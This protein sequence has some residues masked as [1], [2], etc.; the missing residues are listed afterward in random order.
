MFNQLD[1]NGCIALHGCSTSH[2]SWTWS[3]NV[4]CQIVQN[5]YFNFN[6]PYWLIIIF[7]K[8]CAWPLFKSKC[9]NISISYILFLPHSFLANFFYFL[10]DISQG[11][12][13]SLSFLSLSP[14]AFLPMSSCFFFLC[15]VFSQNWERHSGPL[16][17]IPSIRNANVCVIVWP[18]R[19][20]QHLQGSTIR[21]ARWSAAGVR[22]SSGQL[23]ELSLAL[24][25]LNITTF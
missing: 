22:M 18:A 12:F 15:C 11:A 14:S 1:C 20:W 5:S 25:G 8:K 23:M 16:I 13:F 19:A 21:V 6:K 10:G 2:E 7:F 9:F 3:N 4:W 24:S 17:P